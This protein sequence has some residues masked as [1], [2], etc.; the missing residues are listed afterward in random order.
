MIRF[1]LYGVFGWCAE[2]IWTAVSHA[3]QALRAGQRIDVRLAGQTYLWMFSIYGAGGFAFELT[4]RLVGGWPWPARGCLY[5]VGCF[6]IEYCSGWAIKRLTGSVPWDYS[7]ARWRVHNL[8]R[9]DY[10]PLWFGFGLILE[11]VQRLI[12]AAEPALRAT[13]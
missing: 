9:L 10:A 7:Q 3:A 1:V 6:V 13:F 4:H 5:M 2:I 8:I 12:D 11:L